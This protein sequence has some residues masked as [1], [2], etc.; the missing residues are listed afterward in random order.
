MLDRRAVLLGLATTGAI[1][2]GA[3]VYAGQTGRLDLFMPQ[4][5]ED[6]DLP[7]IPGVMLGGA[8]V[9]G[10]TR[11]A[12]FNGVSLLN[13][14]A[15]WCPDCRSEHGVL[16]ALSKRAGIRLFGLAA[17]DTASNAARYLRDAGNPYSRL[18]LDSERT[19]QRALKHRGVPQTYVFNTQGQLVE[20]ISGAMTTRTVE[21]VLLPA[22][23][24]ARRA[25]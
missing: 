25:A 2:A 14:W 16:M 12:F 8:P 22:M 18:S 17:D 11:S 10:L 23:E 4:L 21:S 6:A 19:Y 1:G 20:R 24:K 13:V 7:A 5:P 3:V 9:H 15:S